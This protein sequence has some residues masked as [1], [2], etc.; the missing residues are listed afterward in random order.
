MPLDLTVLEEVD[1]EE[2]DVDEIPKA[3]TDNAKALLLAALYDQGAIGSRPA[4]GS[5]NVRFYRSTDESPSVLYLNTGSTWVPLVRGDDDRLTNARTPVAHASSHAS[6]G[7][8]PLYKTGTASG[9]TDNFG[10]F[11]ATITHNLGA[12]PSFVGVSLVSG[13]TAATVVAQ[14]TSKTSTQATIQILTAVATHPVTIEWMA[15]R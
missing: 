10:V 11:T 12:V 9:T 15:V 7:S 13:Q 1:W 6:G 3:I 4:A 8:D 2:L 14:V 5:T